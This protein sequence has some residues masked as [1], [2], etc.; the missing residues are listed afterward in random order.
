MLTV[1]YFERV[2]D[3]LKK[4]NVTTFPITIYIE[5]Y[6]EVVK[7]WT[8]F[9]SNGRLTFDN[10]TIRQA[11]QFHLTHDNHVLL[12]HALHKD[13]CLLLC[14]IDGVYKFI[15]V[16]SAGNDIYEKNFIATYV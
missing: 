10:F 11:F 13:T 4:P 9:K 14:K 1:A 3:L 16:P 6:D 12:F 5:K 2:K 7:E 15:S 8:K